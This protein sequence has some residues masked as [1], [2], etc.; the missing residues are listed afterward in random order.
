MPLWRGSGSFDLYSSSAAALRFES[1]Y[2]AATLRNASG[3]PIEIVE[4][5][6]EDKRSAIVLHLDEGLRHLGGEGYGLSVGDRSVDLQAATTAGIFFAVQTLLQL[7]PPSI[8][9]QG[10]RPNLTFVLPQVRI[11]DSPRFPWRGAMLDC[12]RYFRPVDLSTSS[13]ICSRSI[14]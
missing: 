14:N 1:E 12:S 7:F 13:S 11:E 10:L 4:T 5:I 8:Y 3:F 2:L 6:S 9:G